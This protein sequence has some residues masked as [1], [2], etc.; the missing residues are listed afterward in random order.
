MLL[1]LT[2]D[3]IIISF[4]LVEGRPHHIVKV[5]SFTAFFSARSSLLLKMFFQK[6]MLNPKYILGRMVGFNGPGF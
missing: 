5:E 6:K 4:A 3:H 2:L 1:A